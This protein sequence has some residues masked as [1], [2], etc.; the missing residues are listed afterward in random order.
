MSFPIGALHFFA[1][2]CQ[3]YA[4][5]CSDLYGCLCQFLY[6]YRLSDKFDCARYWKL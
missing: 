5:L 4:F 2:G 6:T 3:P 1:D